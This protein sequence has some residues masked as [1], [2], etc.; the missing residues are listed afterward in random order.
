M[1]VTH[2]CSPRRSEPSACIFCGPVPHR[3]E[4]SV[5]ENVARPMLDTMADT[6]FWGRGRISMPRRPESAHISRVGSIVDFNNRAGHR[7]QRR[8]RIRRQRHGTES[9]VIG[10]HNLQHREC[11]CE[12]LDVSK[13]H[14][15]TPGG[16]PAEKHQN[17]EP[18]SFLN[19][20][21]RSNVQTINGGAVYRLLPTKAL[22]LQVDF[23]TRIAIEKC[24]VEMRMW[25]Y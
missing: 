2:R 15:D 4:R 17:F 3:Y 6:A 23:S 8:G 25:R 24:H 10:I 18:S 5:A 21:R 22:S 7:W 16:R 9:N 20:K 13:T 14:K 19:D 1:C 12:Y 11:L